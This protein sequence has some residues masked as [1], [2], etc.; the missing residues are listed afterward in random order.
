MEC[1]LHH[2]MG[3]AEIALAATTS[4]TVS[5]CENTILALWT[6]QFIAWAKLH[7]TWTVGAITGGQGT[8]A[9]TITRP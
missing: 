5:L 8:Y 6:A 2:A 1:N 9:V 3:N 4:V 7:P